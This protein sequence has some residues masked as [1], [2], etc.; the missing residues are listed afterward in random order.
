MWLHW[1]FIPTQQQLCW[2]WVVASPS[3][4]GISPVGRDYHHSLLS[5]TNYML[6]SFSVLAWNLS[7]S[8]FSKSRRAFTEEETE[9]QNPNTTCLKSHNWQVTKLGSDSWYIVGA[10]GWTQ[11]YRGWQRWWKQKAVPEPRHFQ[12]FQRELW[13]SSACGVGCGEDGGR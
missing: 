5:C 12:A 11:A 8:P 1:A 4:R 7:L 13:P 3:A 10:T 6:H 2:R 9:S